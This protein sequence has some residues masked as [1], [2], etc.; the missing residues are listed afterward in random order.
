MG[1]RVEPGAKRKESVLYGWHEAPPRQRPVKQA[2]KPRVRPSKAKAVQKLPEDPTAPQERKKTL[3]DMQHRATAVHRARLEVA[4]SESGY[5]PGY[6]SELARQAS[7]MHPH[8]FPHKFW[9][10]TR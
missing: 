7:E 4:R 3:F 2:K 9:S 6:F 1:V 8:G 10:V 5:Q